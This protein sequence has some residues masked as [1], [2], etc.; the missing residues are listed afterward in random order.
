M[1]RFERQSHER[2]CAFITQLLRWWYRGEVVVPSCPELHV[3]GSV[4][5]RLTRVRPGA[6]FAGAGSVSMVCPPPEG[7][8]TGCDFCSVFFS[9]FLIS[10]GHPSPAVATGSA[11]GAVGRSS[12]SKTAKVIVSRKGSL[13]KGVPGRNRSWSSQQATDVSY[14]RSM[15]GCNR[16]HCAECR[17]HQFEKTQET[18]IRCKCRW[19]RHQNIL[20]IVR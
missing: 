12:H 4:K 18:S 13:C 7:S 19:T 17:D 11:E 16:S 5:A 8:A 14:H 6:Q 3:R 10:P 15:C 1:H 9:C 20:F 2:V